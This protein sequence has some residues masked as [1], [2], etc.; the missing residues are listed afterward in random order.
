MCSAGTNFV[1]FYSR[2]LFCDVLRLSFLF[3]FVLLLHTCVLGYD[4]LNSDILI[5]CY[6]KE[7]CKYYYIST[8]WGRGLTRDI[9]FAFVVRG[10]GSRGKIVY[11]K[12]LHSYP[13][14]NGF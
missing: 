10:V 9:Y 7:A 8:L 1:L 2:V 5:L 11:V 6:S 12:D 4:L 14:V 13:P 3:L